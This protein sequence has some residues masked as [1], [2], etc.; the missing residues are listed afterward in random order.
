MANIRVNCPT[1]KAE[2]EIGDEYIGQEAECGKCLQPFKAEDS[3]SVKKPYK[4]QRSRDDEDEEEDERPRRKK[5]RRDD[6]EDDYDYS[7]PGASR[8]SS[9]GSGLGITS[10]I[11]GILSLPLAVFCCCWPVNSIGS[12][13]LQVVG[14][15]LG[16]MGMK[17]SG[18]GVSIAGL[19]ICLVGLA[20]NFLMI[21]LVFGNAFNPNNVN[22]R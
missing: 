4:M 8:G 20:L 17:G 14:S 22:F 9:G 21:V 12:A 6:D 11:L 1:C 10:L 15:I 3:K 18:R 16:F 5:R 7:P 13:I 2:L 19:V